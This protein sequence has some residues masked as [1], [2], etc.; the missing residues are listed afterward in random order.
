MLRGIID[1]IHTLGIEMKA[2]GGSVGRARD[3]YAYTRSIEDVT[4][5][6]KGLTLSLEDHVNF[7]LISVGED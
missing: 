3:Q 5:I 7:I 4:N 1:R 6:L 2:S